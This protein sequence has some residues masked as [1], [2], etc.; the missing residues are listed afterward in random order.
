[1]DCRLLDRLLMNCHLSH[2]P[3]VGRIFRNSY[4][5][6]VDH[7]IVDH[8]EAHFVVRHVQIVMVQSQSFLLLRAWFPHECKGRFNSELPKLMKLESS[9]VSQMTMKISPAL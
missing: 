4:Q 3:I 9:L 5:V 7:H 8:L 6:L 2:Y 1:M